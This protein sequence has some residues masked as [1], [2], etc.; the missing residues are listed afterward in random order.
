MACAGGGSVVLS[1]VHKRSKSR[2]HTRAKKKEKDVSKRVG[3]AV[4]KVVGR[5]GKEEEIE[6]LTGELK[7]GE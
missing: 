7:K 4:E 1:R 5:I 3:L 2:L 6:P